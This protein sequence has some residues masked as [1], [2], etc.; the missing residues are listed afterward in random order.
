MSRSKPHKIIAVYGNSGSYKTSTAVSIAKSISQKDKEADIAII[1]LDSTKPLIPILFPNTSNNGMSLGNVLSAENLDQEMIIANV[2]IHDRIGVIAYNSGENR[3]SYALV[4]ETRI[5]DFITQMRHLVNYTIIDCTCDVVADKFTAKSLIAA[6]NVIYLLSCD[7]N[8]ET[9]YQSQEPILLSEQY[10]YNDYWRF[11]TLNG[12]FDEDID[13]MKNAIPNIGDVIP[14]SSKIT[15]QWNKG[16]ALKPLNDSGYNR[17][18][19]EIAKEL[20][21]D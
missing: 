18:I 11:L 7:I 3:N 9:F 12:K 19:S 15:E 16:E 14:Y 21:E 5:D 10:G 1:G 8:G 4:N 6:D 13:G 17:V 2:H 20:M